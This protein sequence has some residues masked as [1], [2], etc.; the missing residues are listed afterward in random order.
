MRCIRSFAVIVLL[1]ASASLLAADAGERKFIRK[2][3]AEGEVLHK[4]G[5]P[6]HEAFIRVVKGQPEEKS[7]T[8]FPH[9]RDAQT[10]T[11]IT[12]HAGTVSSIERKI[13]R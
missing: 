9:P 1:M 3:M 8:Y 5:K 13:A 6:D 12:F 7:W 11:I 4:L 10:L 2:G